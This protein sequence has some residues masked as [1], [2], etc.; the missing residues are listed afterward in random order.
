MLSV[1]ASVSGGFGLMN[2]AFGSSQCHNWKRKNLQAFSL[3]TSLLFVFVFHWLILPQPCNS[4]GSS[5]VAYSLANSLSY[6]YCLRWKTLW[7]WSERHGGGGGEVK[8]SSVTVH[9]IHV[10]HLAREMGGGRISAGQCV[11]AWLW[12]DGAAAVSRKETRHSKWGVGARVGSNSGLK[13]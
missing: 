11:W 2:S 1:S 8:E 9:V 7:L 6:K 5:S 3:R 10:R 13:T 4:P 12:E